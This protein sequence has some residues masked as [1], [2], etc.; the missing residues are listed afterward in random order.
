MIYGLLHS[1]VDVPTLLIRYHSV[2]FGQGYVMVYHLSL[3]SF[4]QPKLQYLTYQAAL[5][6]AGI[7]SIQILGTYDFSW[8]R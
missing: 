6:Y 2:W 1:S 7:K 3:E 4:K 8:L 5:V